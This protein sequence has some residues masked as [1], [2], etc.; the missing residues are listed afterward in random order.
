MRFTLNIDESLMQSI[1]RYADASNKTELVNT[2]LSEYLGMLRRKAL[3]DLRGKIDLELD[4]DKIRELRNL[5]F[6]SLEQAYAG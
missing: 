6:Q 2:A 3:M 5:D 4:V 1:E